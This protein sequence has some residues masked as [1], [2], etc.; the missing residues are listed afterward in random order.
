MIITTIDTETTTT[1][2][3]EPPSTTTQAPCPSVFTQTGQGCFYADN[4]NRKTL[5]QAEVA[6]QG[7][8]SQVHLA[9][10]DTQQVILSY[11]CFVYNKNVY[12]F[13]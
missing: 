3:T 9:T 12:F 7:F 8:G 5:D 4:T 13:S 11:S 2:T 6:C 1:T 10:V